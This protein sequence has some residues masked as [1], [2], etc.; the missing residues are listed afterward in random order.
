VDEIERL[1]H[2]LHEANEKLRLIQLAHERGDTMAL[3]S[4]IESIPVAVAA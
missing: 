3:V 1:E 4:L 2:E